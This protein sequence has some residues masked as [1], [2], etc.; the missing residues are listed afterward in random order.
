MAMKEKAKKQTS[1]TERNAIEKYVFDQ[2]R[3]YLMAVRKFDAQSTME[4]V[5]VEVREALSRTWGWM[6]RK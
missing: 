6:G 5:V 1:Y 3:L 2:A 4:Q